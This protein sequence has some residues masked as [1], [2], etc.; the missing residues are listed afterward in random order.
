MAFLQRKCAKPYTIEPV[1]P[2]EPLLKLEKGTAIVI[3]SAIQ[4][5]PKYWPN[6]EKFDPE[7]F[8]DE[9]KSK[10]HPYT[11]LPFG[12]GPR[13]CIGNRFTLMEVKTLTFYLLSTFEIVP[14]AETTLKFNMNALGPKPANNTIL[15]F[16]KL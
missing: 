2:E 6:P 4:N 13:M 8:S 16:R 10:I 12:V 9:N 11:Y 5:D 14:V 7:R 15:G 3:P 1:S